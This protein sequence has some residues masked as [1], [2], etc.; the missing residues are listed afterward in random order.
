MPTSACRGQQALLIALVVGLAML[1]AVR[2]DSGPLAEQIPMPAVERAALLERIDALRFSARPDSALPL[3]E[4]WIDT[5]R[6]DG[7][8]AL[9]LGAVLRYGATRVGRGEASAG[10]PYLREAVTVGEALNDTTSTCSALRWLSV[11]ESMQG[12]H[13]EARGSCVRL[14]LLARASGDRQHQGWA[15]VGLG[16]F[17][18]VGGDSE[19][20]ARCYRQ[21]AALFGQTRDAEGLAWAYDALGRVHYRLG[22]YDACARFRE[23]AIAA[24]DSIDFLHQRF[25]MLNNLLNNQGALAYSIGDPATAEHCFRRAYRLQSERGDHRAAVVPGMNLAMCLMRL[26]HWREAETQL[27]ALAN[28][29]REHGLTPLLGRVQTRRATL[30]HQQGRL[31]EATKLYRAVLELEEAMPQAERIGARILLSKSLG[32]LDSTEAALA[33]LEDALALVTESVD[34]DVVLDLHAGLAMTLQELGRYHEALP[35][36]RRVSCQA[37]RLGLRKPLLPAL[38]AAARC[39]W[40]LDAPE[41]AMV[42]FDR[43]VAAWEADR[44]VPLDPEWREER[45]AQ[46]RTL[47]DALATFH[48]DYPSPLSP[49]ERAR[50]AYDSVRIFKARTL[51]ERTLGPGHG[52]WPAMR[53]SVAPAPTVEMLQREILQPGELLLDVFWGPATLYIFAVTRDVC[54]VVEHRTLEDLERRIALVAGALSESPSRATA[55][56]AATL[57]EASTSLSNQLLG[58]LSELIETHD[59]IILSPD[60]ALNRLP[61]EGLP[62]PSSRPDGRAHY[63]SETH[64]IVREPSAS[65]L[66]WQRRA[67]KRD[68][69]SPLGTL[70][71][72][73][74]ARGERGARLPGA[75]EETR[76]L[77]RR[78]R[79]VDI[80]PSET[81]R[82]SLGGLLNAYQVL[83]FAVHTEADDQYPWRS[84]IVYDSCGAALSLRA[85]QI[86]RLHLEAHLAVLSGCGTASGR[87]LSGEGVLGLSSAFLCAGVPT[88]I[89]TLWEAPDRSTVRLVD[90]FYDA[91]ARGLDAS[92]AM[93]E[94][95]ESMRA[96]P[97]TR[98]P[99]Y[100][101]GFVLVGD[102]NGRAVL[103]TRPLWT[104]RPWLIPTSVLLLVA[105]GS[106]L[107]RK[108]RWVRS[109]R[110]KRRLSMASSAWI[111]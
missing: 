92:A 106:V 21:S 34:T 32:E 57:H 82:R 88:V 99:Y 78:Y 60:G 75:Q 58:S 13:A 96:D 85:D 108:W 19:A 55:I 83:H 23:R 2:H 11:A 72:V 53:D 89:A 64:E 36:A 104:R 40:A 41:S 15:L 84:A 7:D 26:G 46:G 87:I 48:L 62:P 1:A 14:Q 3:L 44:A 35:H 5:A 69:A 100:W 56:G 12:R 70:L 39:H 24:A 77:D 97:S 8:S 105:L 95:R 52:P 43:A 86:S 94:A 91:L 16:W 29:C 37:V 49:D 45:G 93:A 6:A 59:R 67:H 107:V 42:Y 111:A 38:H 73:T 28:T 51:L 10:E 31:R 9:L 33:V 47:Y 80:Y 4:R 18:E 54:R 20:A 30:R 79:G 71:G 63:L 81:E 27:D 101:A 17:E 61:L 110:P 22:D 102:G 68:G 66:A 50:R 103:E 98:H 109:Q 74:A 90:R 76:G 65:F 25:Y